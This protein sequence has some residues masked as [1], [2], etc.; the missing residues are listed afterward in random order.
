M[1][2][3]GHSGFVAGREFVT[4]GSLSVPSAFRPHLMEHLCGRMV[5]PEYCS[6]LR[7]PQSTIENG[8]FSSAG[9]G[10]SLLVIASS[11]VPEVE[12]RCNVK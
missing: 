4:T 2:A 12:K 7:Q 10:E 5:W 9:S 3:G 8:V 6:L 1:F 11:E